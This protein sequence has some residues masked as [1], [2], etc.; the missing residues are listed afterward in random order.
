MRRGWR[1]R[2][3]RRR[4]RR[5]ASVACALPSARP[6]LGRVWGA[7]GGGGHRARRTWRDGCSA[8]REARILC[9][10]ESAGARRV[11]WLKAPVEC[12]SSSSGGGGESEP[13]TSVCGERASER[14]DGG[15][16]QELACSREASERVAEERAEREWR[17]VGGVSAGRAIGGV[18]RRK[19]ARARARGLRDGRAAR[20]RA[21]SNG[22]TRRE[23]RA[24][25]RQGRH[26][27][28][29]RGS[30]AGGRGHRR[31]PHV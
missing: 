10:S 20:A 19:W 30:S 22:C 14:A 11:L 26:E 31:G 6:T 4:A 12:G 23:G 1:R 3:R 27:P 5:Q 7:R 24:R 29:S 25:R 18:P 28:A 16:A 17:K 15:G 2:R 13:G 21:R 8:G 9:I